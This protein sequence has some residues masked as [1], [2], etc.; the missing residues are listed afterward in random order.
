M[1]VIVTAGM[2]LRKSYELQGNVR[3]SPVTRTPPRESPYHHACASYLW[4]VTLSERSRRFAVKLLGT[5]PRHLKSEFGSAHCFDTPRNEYTVHWLTSS[6]FATVALPLVSA[7]VFAAPLGGTQWQITIT[8]LGVFPGNL[9]SQGFAIN[10][11]GKIVGTSSAGVGS[12]TVQ[13]I[14]GLISAIPVYSRSGSSIPKDM[15]DQGEIAGTLVISSLMNQGIYW[16]AQNNPF[17]LEGLPSVSGS[18]VVAHGINVSGHIVGRAQEGSPNFAGHAVIWNK[19]TFETDLGFMDGG[20]YSEGYGINDAGDVVGAAGIANGG[21][22][23]FVWKNGQFTDLAT[24]GGGLTSASVAYAINNNGVIVGKRANVA[25]RWAN[26]AFQALPMPA[27][28]SAFTAAV[29]VNDAGDIIATGSKGYPLEVGVL[30]RNGEPIDLGTLPGG[31]ISRAAR[32]NE[33][34]EIVG[35]AKAADGFF[36]AVKWTVTRASPPCA[37]DLNGSGT[38]D[39]ADLAMLLGGW[40]GANPTLDLNHDGVVNAADLATVLS[41]WG[42]CF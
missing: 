24:W 23:A 41:A 34:G 7:P 42:A 27:G 22:H 6:A 32:I 20:S 35:E 28:V 4:S 36:H 8:D 17:P 30:W 15:N 18:Q 19:A 13:W 9:G 25:T 14:N 40:G 11:T 5:R 3:L 10:D 39:A 1:F 38:V 33:A 37:G 16:D 21:L 2:R 12:Y 29:D 31:N 26:G